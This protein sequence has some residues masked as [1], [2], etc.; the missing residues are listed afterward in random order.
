MGKI[1]WRREARGLAQDRTGQGYERGQRLGRGLGSDWGPDWGHGLGPD[2]DHRLVQRLSHNLGRIWVV[3]LLGVVLGGCANSGLEGRF[4]PDPRLTGATPT[5][6]QG[7]PATPWVS[8]SPSPGAI[9]SPGTL[10]STSSSTPFSDLNDAPSAL[11]RLVKE[12]AV[13]G[14]LTPAEAEPSPKESSPPDSSLPSTQTPSSSATGSGTPGESTGTANAFLPNQPIRRRTYARWLFAANNAFN[15][16]RPARTLREAIAT[17]T[18]TFQDVGQDDP[19][20]AA[21]QGLAD[22]GI[23]PSAL[24]GDP[25]VNFRPDATLSREDLVLWKL[26]LDKGVLPKNNLDA[27]KE[28]WAFQ[29]AGKINPRAL[30]AILGDFQQGDQSLIRRVF[31]YTILF[32]PQRSVTRA[33]AA[34]ALWYFGDQ[35]QGMSAPELLRQ[36]GSGD[37]TGQSPGSGPS[38]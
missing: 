5:S 30:G 19:D 27:V 35:N 13:L 18:P 12:V 23:L 26:P 6:P 36:P 2:W 11:G 16:D 10:S 9:A 32:Q 34:A 37:G 22:A 24:S 14:I 17:A 3:S 7:S 8:V 4:S 38:P 31:G 29:D 15:R 20:F 1:V 25:I 21:I 33:E 28:A